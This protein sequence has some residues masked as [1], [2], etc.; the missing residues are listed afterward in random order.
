[1]D[2]PVTEFLGSHEFDGSAWKEL[3]NILQASL[4]MLPSSTFRSAIVFPNQ[5]DTKDLDRAKRQIFETLGEG[6]DGCFRA[7]LHAIREHE[8]PP[9]SDQEVFHLTV[10]LDQMVSFLGQC[11]VEVEGRCLSIFCYSNQPDDELVL[12]MFWRWWLE[13]NMMRFVHQAATDRSLFDRYFLHH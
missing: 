1:M 3:R 4:A 11:F 12:W 10:C 2:D 6:H 13:G 9:L 7:I 5:V 8:W